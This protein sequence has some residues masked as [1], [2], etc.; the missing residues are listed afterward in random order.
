MK[1]RLITI[2]DKCSIILI[3]IFDKCSIILI[4]IFGKH[5]I[6]VIVIFGESSKQVELVSYRLDH[7]KHAGQGKRQVVQ[8]NIEHSMRTKLFPQL[9][10]AGIEASW[11]Q[12]CSSPSSGS[13]YPHHCFLLSGHYDSE[14][15]GLPVPLPEPML[16][17]SS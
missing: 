16:P 12:R 17:L 7:V 8:V 2:F 15:L 11:I 10:S 3:V 13:P 1:E 9:S 5:L 6:I 4:V 14:S